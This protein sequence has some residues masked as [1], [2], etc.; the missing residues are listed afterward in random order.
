LA[1]FDALKLLVQFHGHLGWL[2]AAALVHPAI[3]LGRRDLRDPKQTMGLA[4]SLATGLITV[5]ALSGALVYDD[6]RERVRPVLFQVTPTVGWMFERKEHLAFGAALLAWAGVFAAVG[7][8]RASD[9]GAGQRLAKASHRAFIV[10]AAL[11]ILAATLGTW[12][13]SVRSL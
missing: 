3:L 11:A 7:A 13:A 9:D 8:R 12:V 1:A 6:Y 10:S 2:A 5:A 4:L